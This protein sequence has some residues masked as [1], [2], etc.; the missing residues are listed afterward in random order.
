MAGSA[1][2][3]GGVSWNQ[4]WATEGKV[5]L[6]VFRYKAFPNITLKK[7]ILPGVVAHT[8]NPSTQEAEAGGSV[9]VRDWPGLQK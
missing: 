5:D 9:Q 3:G 2:P 1:S 4:T 6:N 7:Q 8:Y